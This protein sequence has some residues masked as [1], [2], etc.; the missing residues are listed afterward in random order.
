MSLFGRAL[1][2]RFEQKQKNQKGENGQQGMPAIDRASV[3]GDLIP[4]AMKGG[5]ATL[6]QGLITGSNF[7]IGILLARWLPPEQYGAYAVA[8]AVFLLLGML[9]QALFLE[10]QS[11]FGASTYRGCF[12]GY[13]KA[14]VRLHL[15]VALGMVL[16]LG[17]SAEVAL[18]RGQP[19]GLPGALAGVAFAAPC[20][21]LFWLAR[22]TSYLEFSPAPAA[23]G[24]LFY[25]ALALTGLYLA[26]RFHLLSPMS[27]L[28]LMGLGAVGAGAFLFI[29]LKWRLP[30]SLGAPSLRDT[31]R[32]HWGYGRWALASAALI[33][34]PSYIF[35][36]LLSSS[37]GMTQAAELKALMNFSAPVLQTCSAFGPLLIPYA[38][39]THQREGYAGTSALARR[40]SLLCGSGAVVYWLPLL[41]FRGPA[42]RLLYS[43]RYTEVA[44][45]LPVVALGSVSWS[46]AVG[47]ANAFRGTASPASV[48]VAALVSSCVSLAIGVPAAWA[49]GVR[50]AVWSMALSEMLGFVM[51]LVLFRRKLRRASNAVATLPEL[52]VSR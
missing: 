38:A 29:Y 44:Y 52:S 22:R 13:L 24:S 40:I 42:F 34:V 11:V 32:S 4:W 47:L 12:R 6:D 10:P 19:G 5:L 21:F 1:V 39:R 17:A 9:Y 46:A 33:W 41:L 50:G 43:G 25:C 27:S 16:V 36:P 14:L 7:V 45:L 26:N 48:F 15:V 23:G 20:I 28:L 35:Y 2:E 8:F 30:S 37:F 51:A 49:L 31:W 18:K 3:W